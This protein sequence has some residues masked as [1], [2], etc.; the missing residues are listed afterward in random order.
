MDL[1][2]MPERWQVD[3]QEDLEMSMHYV[4]VL[5]HEM[6]NDAAA[7]QSALELQKIAPYLAPNNQFLKMLSASK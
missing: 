2:K 4:A 7:R 6:G 3:Q 1:S 5:Q